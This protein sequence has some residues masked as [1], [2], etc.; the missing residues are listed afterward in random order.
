MNYLKTMNESTNEI[1]AKFTS[2]CTHGRNYS[3][4]KNEVYNDVKLSPGLVC[5]Q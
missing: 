1:L 4:R 5:F 3:K 2:E